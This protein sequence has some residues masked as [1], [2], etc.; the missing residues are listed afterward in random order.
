MLKS[1]LSFPT[2]R[3]AVLWSTYAS[4]AAKYHSFLML[5][6]C[7]RQSSYLCE[8]I[9]FH[10]PQKIVAP[11]DGRCLFASVSVA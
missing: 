1:C 8:S 7:G 2:S 11:C 3:E 9:Y 4:I 10:I 5:F 6:V